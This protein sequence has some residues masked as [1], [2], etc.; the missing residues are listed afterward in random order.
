MGKYEPLVWEVFS[1]HIG[2]SNEDSN[3]LVYSLKSAR[4]WSRM[5]SILSNKVSPTAH[6][7]SFNLALIPAP[8]GIPFES[9]EK[10]ISC[11]A[12]L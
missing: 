12:F 7:Y 4:L 3:N 9:M 10:L 8:V 5:L 2:K 6:W 1:F 11:L